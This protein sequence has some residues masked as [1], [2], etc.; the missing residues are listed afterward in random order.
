MFKI[1]VK[2]CCLLSYALV[3]FHH[4]S[5]FTTVEHNVNVAEKYKFKY[6]LEKQ[7]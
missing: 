6:F 7:N 4:D 2:K 3:A 1:N 5:N